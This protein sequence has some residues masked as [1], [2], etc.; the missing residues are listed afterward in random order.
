MQRNYI[1]NRHYRAEFDKIDGQ[2]I[3]AI[4]RSAK[5]YAGIL[6]LPVSEKR[7]KQDKWVTR[8]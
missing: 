6:H 2:L 5:A 7:G 3:V 4:R 8:K 1:C